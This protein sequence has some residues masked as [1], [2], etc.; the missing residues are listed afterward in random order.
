MSLHT[1]HGH[2]DRCLNQILRGTLRPGNAS[3]GR[4][5]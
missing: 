3:H 2:G 4:T 5:R 1:N